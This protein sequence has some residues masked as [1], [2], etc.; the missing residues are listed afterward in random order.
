MTV[1]PEEFV[2]SK[3]DDYQEFVAD[4]ISPH[5]NLLEP[6]LLRMYWALSGA[7]A[8]LGEVSELFEKYLRKGHTDFP[9]EKLLDE[10]GDTVW[11]LT[12][13]LELSDYSLEKCLDHNTNKLKE[14]RTNE[15][16]L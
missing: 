6:P 4:G 11:F 3:L 12:A 8:E 13:L 10:I 15:V 2:D 1:V 14:R 16:P 9:W 7:Q 5:V